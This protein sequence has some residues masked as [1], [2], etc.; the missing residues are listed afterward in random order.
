MVIFLAVL[1]GGT[2]PGLAEARRRALLTK[3]AG[4]ERGHP[5][6]EMSRFN[7]N[8]VAGKV[9]AGSDAGRGICDGRSSS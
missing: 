3:G 7:P 4:I 9:G 6:Q 1:D 5:C 2:L 8:V